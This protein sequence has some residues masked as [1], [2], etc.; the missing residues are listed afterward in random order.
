MR[1]APRRIFQLRYASIVGLKNPKACVPE[2]YPKS[3]LSG[4]SG[5]IFQVAESHLEIT[6]AAL[7]IGYAVAIAIVFFASRPISI[8][9]PRIRSM[10]WSAH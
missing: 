9:R 10:D 7:L 3:Q 1:L 8:N 6:M 5:G 2:L 4:C